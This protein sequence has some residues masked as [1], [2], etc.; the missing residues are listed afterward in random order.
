[1]KTECTPV[2]IE[3]QGLG[4]R[5]VEAAF[6]GGHIS[7]DGGALLLRETDAR[8]GVTER[9]AE[10]FTDLRDQERVEHSVLE[11]LRQRVYGIALGYEDLNDHDDLMRDPLL[12]LAL[13]KDDPQGQGR[14]REQDRGKALA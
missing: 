2:Q 6:D 1:M 11:L 4:R 7:S 3:F 14:R 5:K 8:F 13:G 9:L 10:C 12:A